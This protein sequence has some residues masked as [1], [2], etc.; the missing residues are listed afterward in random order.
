LESGEMPIWPNDSW[1]STETYLGMTSIL[2]FMDVQH[3][4]FQQYLKI[5]LNFYLIFFKI[6]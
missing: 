6:A 3:C 2:K 1:F 5:K 4:I